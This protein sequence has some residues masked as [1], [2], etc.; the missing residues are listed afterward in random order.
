MVRIPRVIIAKELDSAVTV[1][2]RFGEL[3]EYCRRERIPLRIT[4]AGFDFYIRHFLERNRWSSDIDVVAPTMRV[5][6]SGIRF[7]FPRRLVEGSVNFK[8]DRV[9]YYK[10]KGRQVAYLGDGKS[11]YEAVRNADLPF[12]VKGSKL[13]EFCDRDGVEHFPFEN[14]R[15][16]VDRIVEFES[17]AHNV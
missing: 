4:S 2:P 13:E 15:E 5:T 12:V 1:R 17:S 3:V 14:F 6:D 7:K 8:D 11:D 9:R 10:R 16:V